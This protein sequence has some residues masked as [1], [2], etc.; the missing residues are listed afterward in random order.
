MDKD[1]LDEYVFVNYHTNFG[2]MSNDA[3]VWIIEA[4]SQTGV[5]DEMNISPNG[6]FLKQNFPNPFN[7]ST[8]IQYSIN[9]KQFVSLKVYDVLGNEVASLVNEE[10]AAGAH[11]I[12]FNAENLPSGVYFY[13]IKTENFVEARKMLLIR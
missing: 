13:K 3:Y 11:D 9:I 8:K 7:P 5:E 10:K 6:Y 1:G 2:I 12:I 4:Q